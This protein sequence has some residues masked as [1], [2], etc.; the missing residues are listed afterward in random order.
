MINVRV[1]YISNERAITDTPKDD[2]MMTAHLWAARDNKE[3]IIQ[4]LLETRTDTREQDRDVT[5]SV[6]C[7]T[8][9]G[10]ETTMRLLLEMEA[11]VKARHRN[12]NATLFLAVFGWQETV[13]QLLLE[14]G[15]DTQKNPNGI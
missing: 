2:E 5:I 11:S 15:V 13:V 3:A 10:Y 8:M 6:C 4:A 7:A 12:G 1:L 14:S 9:E